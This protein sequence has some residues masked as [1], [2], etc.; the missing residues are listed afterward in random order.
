MYLHSTS[1]AAAPAHTTVSSFGNNRSV[2]FAKCQLV[3]LEFLVFSSNV[4]VLELK[5]V[6]LGLWE[7]IERVRSVE[8]LGDYFRAVWLLS[9]I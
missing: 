1:T 3:L 6:I 4:N 5:A 8:I 7:A 9:M 2:C